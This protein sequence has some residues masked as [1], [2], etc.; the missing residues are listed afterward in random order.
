VA[1]KF[2]E[3]VESS[4][5]DENL[6]SFWS[7]ADSGNPMLRFLLYYRI[8]EYAAVHFID[9]GIRSELKKL[10]LTPDL[11]NDLGL[12][13][14]KM[15]SAMSV[16]KLADS[17]RLRSLVRA[18]V[19]PELLWR[20]LDANKEFF[21]KDTN[22]EGGFCVRSPIGK[23]DTLSTFGV[24]GVERLADRFRDIRNALSH[25]KDQEKGGVIRPTTGNGQLFGPWVHLIA[26]AAGEVVLFKDAT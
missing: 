1:G 11:K 26:T 15:V 5:V 20:D 6:L 14:E 12:S 21:S 19:N 16:S 7:F 22:F 9:D 3:F 10:I 23:N 25:G 24:N 18:S 8:L 17:Q 2:P 4:T 13:I